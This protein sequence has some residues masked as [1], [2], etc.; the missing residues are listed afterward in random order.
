VVLLVN[1]V[2]L[3]GP[4][5]TWRGTQRLRLVWQAK[6]GRTVAVVAVCRLLEGHFDF[7]WCLGH[8]DGYNCSVVG[9]LLDFEDR[10]M[11]AVVA[12][13]IV[14]GDVVL[15]TFREFCP[16]VLP[17]PDAMQYNRSPLSRFT[18]LLSKK[19]VSRQRLAEVIP[20]RRLE[21]E[22]NQD[23]LV[24]KSAAGFPQ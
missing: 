4:L 3:A 12:A 11:K 15:R 9:D 6:G 23:K 22:T 8:D 7:C 2:A 17:S 13:V 10:M 24:I 16:P 20:C 18:P 21:W 5:N 14:I 19:T 1:A